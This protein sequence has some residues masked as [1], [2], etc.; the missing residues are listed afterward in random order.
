M[1]GDRR[2]D[3]DAG[4]RAVAGER[5]SERAEERRQVPLLHAD[6]GPLAAAGRDVVT[7]MVEARIRDVQRAPVREIGVVVVVRVPGVDH[8]VDVRL[9]RDLRVVERPRQASARVVRRLWVAGILPG[10]IRD[11]PR[12]RRSDRRVAADACL[13]ALR[14]LDTGCKRSRIGAVLELTLMGV[15]IADVDDKRRQQQEDRES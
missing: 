2:P 1:A 4:A 9:V 8:D 15:P 12:G 7:R 11:P 5:Q 14:V 6:V 13:P 10:R 3:L